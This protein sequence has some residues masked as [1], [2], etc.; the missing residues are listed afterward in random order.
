MTQNKFPFN[1]YPLIASYGTTDGNIFFINKQ[2]AIDTKT[3]GLA[4]RCQST[5]N[6]LVT[7]IN[8]EPELVKC[9]NV[10]LISDGNNVS[11]APGQTYL[12]PKFNKSISD[13][14]TQQIQA[15]KNNKG[16]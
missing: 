1:D 8:D 10:V 16:F 2:N 13:N 14:Q 4:E 5:T 3:V 7:C 11:A 6:S 12:L 15:S 9:K